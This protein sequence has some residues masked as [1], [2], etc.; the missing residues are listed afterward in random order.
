[1]PPTART[2]LVCVHGLDGRPSDL[3]ALREVLLRDAG[4]TTFVHLSRANDGATHGGIELAAARLASEI[5]S[6]VSR[7]PWLTH[8][9]LVGNS[10]GGLFARYAAALL[11]EPSTRTLCGLTPLVF[12]TTASPHLGVGQHGHLSLVPAPLQALSAAVLGAS[13]REL[14][15]HDGTPSR[16]PLLYR[17]TLPDEE[18][19]LPFLS[20]LAAFRVRHLYANAV[21]D[22]LVPYE[23]AACT[24]DPL[25]GRREAHSGPPRVLFTRRRP[26]QPPPPPPPAV[27]RDARGLQRHMA[28][29]L[30]TVEWNETA[31]AFPSLLPLAHNRIVA[32]RR[33]GATSWLNAVGLGVVEH[34]GGALLAARGGGG[35]VTEEG[36][37][38]L[39]ACVT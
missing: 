29:R 26:A 14:L 37:E 36:V 12:L 24:L 10:L 33:D 3:S 11:F 17:M 19:G 13:I 39:A 6:L 2:I 4:G 9:S 16:V 22:F 30:A 8:L 25:E 20:A 38:E 27:P 15:L 5:R 7:A 31:V 32:L 1:M 34:P 23:T 18:S 35:G 21:N 28:A